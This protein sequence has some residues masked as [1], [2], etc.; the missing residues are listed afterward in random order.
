MTTNLGNLQLNS[1]KKSGIQ[2]WL[3]WA[4]THQE[5][6]AVIGIIVILLGIGIPYYFHSRAQSATEAQG[7]LSLG[8]YYL[9][10]PVDP[11]NG[12]FKTNWEKNQQAL[13]TF[14]HLI[15]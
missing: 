9:H 11:K 8:Q 13:Q 2:D 10:S 12:P 6:I 1:Q 4:K 3:E 5:I 15:N 7:V 14:Q